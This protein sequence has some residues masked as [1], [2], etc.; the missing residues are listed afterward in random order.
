[1]VASTPRPSGSTTSTCGLQLT[2]APSPTHS[3]PTLLLDERLSDIIDTRPRADRW[4]SPG[5]PRNSP[6]CGKPPQPGPVVGI[7]SLKDPLTGVPVVRR[8][9]TNE[10]YNRLTILVASLQFCA[11]VMPAASTASLTTTSPTSPTSRRRSVFSSNVPLPSSCRRTTT[12]ASWL[13]PR[14]R[15]ESKAAVAA[16]RA[17]AAGAFLNSLPRKP[18]L[19]LDEI[20]FRDAVCHH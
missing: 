20:S 11:L 12:S 1:M 6:R 17:P 14:I 19:K 4:S 3:L 9:R 2:P 8:L 7:M 5:R 15:A 13:T 18:E 10:F 16:C